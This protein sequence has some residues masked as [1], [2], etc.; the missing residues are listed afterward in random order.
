MRTYSNDFGF[1]LAHACWENS[2]KLW[3]VAFAAPQVVALRTAQLAAS[4]PFLGMGAGRDPAAIG[5]EKVAALVESWQAMTMQGLQVQQRLFHQALAQW[6]GL[7]MTAAAPRR[8][9]RPDAFRAT[10]VPVSTGAREPAA[11]A[12]AHATSAGLAPVH[13][14]ATNNVHR[15]APPRRKER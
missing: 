5:P 10:V 2:I 6:W 15:L 14:R 12:A 8:Q 9:A 4:A 7:W 13:R 1:G 11:Q 3:E